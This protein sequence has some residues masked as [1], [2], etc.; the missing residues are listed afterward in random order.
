MR[1]YYYFK[2]DG[3]TS[4]RLLEAAKEVIESRMNDAKPVLSIK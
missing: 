4:L 3:K 1:E 2:P